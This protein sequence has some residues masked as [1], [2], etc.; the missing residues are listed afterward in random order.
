MLQESGDAAAAL[1]AV[2]GDVALVAS[3]AEAFARHL[4]GGY[5]RPPAGVPTAPAG[6]VLQEA[7]PAAAARSDAAI[8]GRA[9]CATAATRYRNPWTLADA[10]PSGIRRPWRRRTCPATRSHS[11]G[12][13]RLTG[14]I[15]RRSRPP[16]P[17]PS[18]T[19]AGLPFHPER[20]KEPQVTHPI[21]VPDST[22]VPK[23]A[24][25]SAEHN[26]ASRRHRI[27]PGGRPR[28]VEERL[29]TADPVKADAGNLAAERK[30]RPMKKLARQQNRHAFES[31]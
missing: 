28:S 25:Q 1:R 8:S 11:A 16:W 15:E 9:C 20:Q 27:P 23:P 22:E 21:P 30:R 26:A 5:V 24:R 4:S 12:R 19:A 17:L 13:L 14:D 2:G 31:G 18:G 7:D 10:M 3:D 29:A 6:H